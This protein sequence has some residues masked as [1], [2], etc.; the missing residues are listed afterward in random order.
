MRNPDSLFLGQNQEAILCHR[1]VERSAS[2][3]PV[4]EELIEGNGIE[5]RAGEQVGAHL[6]PLLDEAN[7]LIAALRLT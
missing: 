3:P 6:G 5:H 4:G 7:G 2:R 1:R